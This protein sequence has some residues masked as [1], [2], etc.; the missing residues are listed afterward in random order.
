MKTP[1]RGL[2]EIIEGTDEVMDET[3]DSERGAKGVVQR[4][5]NASSGLKHLPSSVWRCSLCVE[6]HYHLVS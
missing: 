1:G 3:G 5:K 4:L 6:H 2:L